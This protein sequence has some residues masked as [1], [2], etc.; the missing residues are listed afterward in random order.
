[1]GL[2]I[3]RVVFFFFAVVVVWAM[4]LLVVVV[5]SIAKG[6]LFVGKALVGKDLVS[7]LVSLLVSFFSLGELAHLLTRGGAC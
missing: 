5:E 1:M 2:S 3:S 7:L 6:E 4:F